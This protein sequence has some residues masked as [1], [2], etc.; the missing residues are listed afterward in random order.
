M[1]SVARVGSALGAGDRSTRSAASFPEMFQHQARFDPEIAGQIVGNRDALQFVAEPLNRRH[2]E[3]EMRRRGP[4][5]RA[6]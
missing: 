1:R 6:C 3:T 4:A 2:A 5:A